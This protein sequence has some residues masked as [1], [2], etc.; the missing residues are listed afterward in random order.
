MQNAKLRV[1][2]AILYI[3]NMLDCRGR[4]PCLP[5]NLPQTCGRA[6]R[7]DPTEQHN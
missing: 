2:D 1:C 7:P 6:Q 5:E 3:T 4:S